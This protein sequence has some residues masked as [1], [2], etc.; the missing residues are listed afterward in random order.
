MERAWLSNRKIMIYLDHAASTPMDTIAKKALID[1]LEEYPNPSSAHSLGRGIADKII[2]AK[3]DFY[4]FVEAKKTYELLFTSSATESNNT[5]ISGLGLKSGDIVYCDF[6]DHASQIVPLKNIEG[7]DL[8]SFK[9]PIDPNARLFSFPHVNGQSGEINNYLEIAKNIKAKTKAY[10]HM[11]A[12]QSFTKISISLKDGL[13]DSMSFSG[14]KMG[15]PKGIGGLFFKKYS[16]KPF[17]LGGGHQNDMRASTLSWPLINSFHKATQ[18]A[19]LKREANF[20]KAKKLQEYFIANL[21]HSKFLFE[22]TSPYITSFAYLKK[23]SEL[24]LKE[25]DDQGIY[26]SSTSA[27]SSEKAERLKVFSELGIEQSLHA[28]MLRVSLGENSTKAE[29]D[30]LLSYLN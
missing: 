15:G 1:S 23:T 12:S 2:M 11:D 21:K 30:R 5:I 10:I 27:C 29:L 16:I 26:I 13:V 18:E 8:R 24:V 14:H 3:Q 19:L 7:L 9:D 4:N 20:N 6:S 25:L 22:N 28:H 17:L